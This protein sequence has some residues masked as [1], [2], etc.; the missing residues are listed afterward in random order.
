M[1]DPIVNGIPDRGLS[2]RNLLQGGVAASLAAAFLSS[3]LCEKAQGAVSPLWVHPVK[4]REHDSV[5]AIHVDKANHR[6]SPAP[7]LHEAALDDV[8]G[9]QVPPQ[10]SGEVE[11]TEQFGQVVF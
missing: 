8:G 9:A 4:D 5:H 6:S 10:M 11:E 7:D 2:R 3:C 1:T